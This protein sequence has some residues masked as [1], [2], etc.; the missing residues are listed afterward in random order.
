MAHHKTVDI[1]SFVS[2][3]AF[4]WTASATSFTIRQS[5]SPRI[6]AW[7][8]AWCDWRRAGRRI[9]CLSSIAAD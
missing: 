9:A 3:I 1:P 4:A 5:I 8:T 7:C 6:A 2:P